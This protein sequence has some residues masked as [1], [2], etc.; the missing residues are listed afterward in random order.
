M[1]E[2][3][4]VSRSQ[5]GVPVDDLVMPE[6]FFGVLGHLSAKRD[7]DLAELGNSF[8]KAGWSRHGLST[9][10]STDRV[11]DLLIACEDDFLLVAEIPEERGATDLRS[12]DDVCN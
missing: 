1:L 9:M 5:V 2:L 3:H 10:E 6:E 4:G 7:H 12:V 8:G 11:E